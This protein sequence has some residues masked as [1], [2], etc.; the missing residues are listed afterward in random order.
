MSDFEIKDNVL[1][2]YHGKEPYLMIPD[3]ITRIGEYA[4]CDREH[5][6]T[7]NQKIKGV[8]IP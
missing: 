3:G 6:C 2:K 1:I 8:C 5:L 7:G 4:F